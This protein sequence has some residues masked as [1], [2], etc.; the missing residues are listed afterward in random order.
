MIWSAMKYYLI[1]F[2]SI[3]FYTI[4]IYYASLFAGSSDGTGGGSGHWEGGCGPAYRATTITFSLY[5]RRFGIRNWTTQHYTTRKTLHFIS[6]YCEGQ[7][8]SPIKEIKR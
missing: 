7:S 6:F 1:I 8:Q 3:P 5:Q 4:S 2:N